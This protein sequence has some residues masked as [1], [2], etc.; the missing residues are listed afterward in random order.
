MKSIGMVSLIVLL[1]GAATAHA[2]IR[3]G[4]PVTA[5][6]DYAQLDIDCTGCDGG[7]V[8][9]FDYRLMRG[10]TLIKD[11]T[12]TGFPSLP[13]GT[14]EF[15]IPDG[16]GQKGDYEFRLRARNKTE[17]SLTATLAYQVQSILPNRPK[18][19]R[20]KP[21][22]PPP[23]LDFAAAAEMGHAYAYLLRLSRLT[24]AELWDFA[25]LYDGPVPLTQE[26]VLD[27]LDAQAIKLVPPQQ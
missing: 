14:F 6:W 2:Q 4:D 12:D 20:L 9:G 22:A 11:W 13:P 7:P 15:V 8:L 1:G 26:S 17:F 18:N 25:R 19:L 27:F 10:T 23:P 3:I 16:A 24:D 21:A 5:L